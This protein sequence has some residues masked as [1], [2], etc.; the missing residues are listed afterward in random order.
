MEAFPIT[1][2]KAM[3]LGLY[4]LGD[5]LPPIR[6]GEEI[7]EQERIGQIIEMARLAEEAGL[8]VFGVGESHQKH[9]VASST[10]TILATIAGV[11]KNI[12]LTS[13]VTVLSTADPVRVCEDFSTLDLLSG[14]R[15]EI[16]AG[17]GSRYGAYE[18]FG[19][20]LNDYEELFDEKLEL[21]QQLNQQQPVTWEGNFRP[22]LQ[23][24]ALYPKPL[25]GS[26]PIWYAVGQHHASAMK[27][28]RLGM[29]IQLA[30]LYGASSVFEKRVQGYRRSAVEAGHDPEKLPVSM[31]SMLY[32]GDDTSTAMKEYYPYLNH[33]SKVNWGTSFPKDRFAEASSI[34]N[35]MMVGSTQQIIEKILYQYEL[36]GHQRFLVQIDH[37]NIPYRKVMD[38]IELFASEIAPVVRKATA[39]Q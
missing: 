20:D 11:T 3:E 1:Q 24:A 25:G 22:A 33:T 21:L 2:N 15:A 36:F 38:M 27:A 4:T 16:V 9:F 12:K 28:G 39:K 8:D 7:S 18:L 35:A 10:P 19:Y 14:G 34:K 26:L 37:G 17:R 6:D 32:V 5:L 30:G 31:A 23:E 13:S 29:P